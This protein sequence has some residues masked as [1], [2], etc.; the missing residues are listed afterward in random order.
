MADP[1]QNSVQDLNFRLGI[2][3]ATLVT[4]KVII[5]KSRGEVS[6]GARLKLVSKDLNHL[7]AIL[8]VY[9]GDLIFIKY[10]KIVIIFQKE[11]GNTY[12]VLN[13]FYSEKSSKRAK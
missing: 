3:W 7:A 2:Q 13:I 10:K 5:D 9:A 8:H 12:T 4:A 6:I 1:Y 11:N